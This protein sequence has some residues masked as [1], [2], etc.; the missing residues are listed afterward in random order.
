MLENN[1]IRFTSLQMR[2][3][4][5]G[6]AGIQH[7]NNKQAILFTRNGGVEWDVVNPPNSIILSVYPINSR[8]SWAY[9]L[10]KVDDN[11]EP[12]IFYTVNRGG[13]WNKFILP[14]E[15]NW[16]LST[17]VQVQMHATNMGSI[18]IILSRK[19]KSNKFQHN[20]YYTKSK[21]RVWKVIRNINIS[22]SISGVT[23]I[24]RLV[25]FISLQKNYEK[26]T[27]FKTID[28]GKSWSPI[29]D[30]PSIEGTINGNSMAYKAIYKNNLLAIPTKIN[31]NIFFMNYSL[32]NGN[33]WHI[34][35]EKMNTSK[36]AVSFFS[37][38]YGWVINRENGGVYQIK[39]KG[40]EWI[41]LSS[42]PLLKSVF[43]LHFLNQHNGWACSKKELFTTTDRGITWENV[44]YK[45]N[46][47]DK[48]T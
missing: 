33:T 11:R 35:N 6:W 30:V 15:E 32:D 48:L 37:S 1:D 3:D 12:A 26:S 8:S 5:F 13:K 28:G 31:N 45:I 43:C 22:D 21:G 9:G 24:N 40:L 18:W 16:E 20:L 44:D 29:K 41:E 36:V 19:L 23:F 4:R 17:D 39:K 14:I 42:N 27:V 38:Q 46:Q 10:T 25:G 34:S 7:S 47:I 2:T